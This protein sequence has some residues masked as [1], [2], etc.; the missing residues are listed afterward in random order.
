MKKQQN[1]SPINILVISPFFY[2]HI[3]G[4]Q[5][6]IEEL[7]T[8]MLEKH[9][10]I[11]VTV[12]AYNTDNAPAEE[13]YR[14][15]T[16]IRIP[17]ISILPGQFAL[18]NP[19]SIISHLARL[20]QKRFDYVHTHIR[21][22]DSTWW[23]W[24]YANII[25][26]KSIFTEHV[27]THPVHPNIWI[28]RIAT[29]IDLTLARW[30]INKYDL[31]TTTNT[32]AKKFL[33]QTLGTRKTI[34]ISYGGVDTGF[35][36][37]K[38][39]GIKYIPGMKKPL[40]YDVIVISY[41]GRLIWSKG[42][43]Y[44]CSAIQSLDTILPNNVIFVLGG[45]GKLQYWLEKNMKKYHMKKR[46]M[47]VGPLSSIGVRNLLKN[48]DI[49]IHPSHHNE[50]FPNSVLEAASSGAF[51]IATDNGGTNEI[52][53]DKITGILIPQK[54]TQAIKKAILWA[55]EH[56]EKRVEMAQAGRC[57]VRQTFD[58]RI[59]SESFYALIQ[60]KTP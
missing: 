26:A 7:Y 11:H 16:I 51:V 9:P 60:T 44:L 4:S 43:T 31:V 19:I 6:Y 1:G 24:L 34:H 33:E 42:L 5:R 36:S 13:W 12:L 22:F 59:I 45:E 56:E 27:A 25:G 35:F 23:V 10:N 54:N 14:G 47:Y 57:F 29:G 55:L 46:I 39:N 15:M 53:S 20:S 38:Q 8:H 40:P 48:T 30:A 17:C 28:T 49:F 2:P 37:P 21:F 52:I 3:G 41:I 50:G 18:P 58:W 32:P